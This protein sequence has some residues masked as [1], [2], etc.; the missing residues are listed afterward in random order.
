MFSGF[1]SGTIAAYLLSPIVMDLF[2]NGGTIGNWR[3]LFYTYGLSGLVLLILWLLLAKDAPSIHQEEH[4][5]TPRT[6]QPTVKS[7]EQ[8]D[9]VG[10][11]NSASLSLLS[12]SSATLSTAAIS[13]TPVG[14][15]WN[16]ETTNNSYCIQDSLQVTDNG[17]I[18][19]STISNTI[20]NKNN[21]TTIQSL[22]NDAPWKQMI[23][24]KGVWAMLLAHCSK[25]Y[26][27]YNTLSWSPTFY[28][29][30]Y[31][32]GVRDSAMLSI[33]PSIAGIVGSFVAG[34]SVDT[35]FRLLARSTFSLQQKQDEEVLVVNS[36]LISNLKNDNADDMDNESVID[37]ATKTVVRKVYQSIALY[38]G[39]ISLGMLACNLL[40]ETNQNVHDQTTIQEMEPF[41]AQLYITVSVALQAFCGAGFEGGNQDKAGSKW[42]GLL[43][44]V[45]SL[46]AVLC[47]LI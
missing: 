10:S 12:S 15:V 41:T 30:Q 26:A 20:T 11:S 21:T 14:N 43:Y 3:S 47:K 44:S 34:L 7:A 35:I 16:T 32:I 1:K 37:D 39:A 28:Y 42:T 31:G 6:D 36:F 9:R 46:P 13:S 2:T 38:G 25:N 23:Q 24:S 4:K 40:A 19:R 33:L 29:E 27:L 45:T 22:Y 17:K 8:L 18:T 5:L